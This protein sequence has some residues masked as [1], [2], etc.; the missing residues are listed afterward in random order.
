[1]GLIFMT[2]PDKSVISRTLILAI[3]LLGA[4]APLQM[5]AAKEIYKWVDPVGQTHY[6]QLPPPEGTTTIDVRSAPPPAADSGAA[7]TRLQQQVET[8]DKQIEAEDKAKSDAEMD[9]EIARITKENCRIAKKNLIGLQQGGEKRYRT[10]D[11]EV[12]RLTEEERQQR[13]EE[14][15]SQIQEFCK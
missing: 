1:M 10:S 6:T 12:V 15:E 8:M 5:S 4:T 9:A 11:G 2:H 3:G 13:I 7:D 14:A